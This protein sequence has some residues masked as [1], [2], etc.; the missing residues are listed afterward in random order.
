MK[1]RLLVLAVLHA[2]V[3]QELVQVAY[4]LVD[5]DIFLL[6]DQFDELLVLFILLLDLLHAVVLLLFHLLILHAFKFLLIK[7]RIIDALTTLK[8]LNL[9]AQPLANVAHLV[10]CAQVLRLL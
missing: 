10:L 9:P 7:V 4:L 2:L 1:A 3:Q 5:V 6:C 8:E